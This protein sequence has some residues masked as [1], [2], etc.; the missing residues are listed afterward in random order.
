MHWLHH[1][2]KEIACLVYWVIA[3]L[4]WYACRSRLTKWS[5]HLKFLL[6]IAIWLRIY[7]WYPIYTTS[8]RLLT[9]QVF[10]LTKVFS[11]SM[12][13][14][15]NMSCVLLIGISFWVIL[16]VFFV[17]MCNGVLVM[18]DEVA[19]GM[20]GAVVVRLANF[21]KLVP[22]WRTRT[23]LSQAMSE[24]VC[25][26]MLIVHGWFLSSFLFHKRPY[27]YLFRSTLLIFLDLHSTQDLASQY[28]KIV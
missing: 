19:L 26:T 18:W 17:F 23:L 3:Q 10:R 24:S 8:F 28:L 11:R 5:Q 13:P 4:L 15:G 25:I 2:L 21:S 22:W 1:N 6:F 9:V 14:T 7:R 27:L 16:V 12:V 20:L